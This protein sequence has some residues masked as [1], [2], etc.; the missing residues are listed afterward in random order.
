MDAETKQRFD[1]LFRRPLRDDQLDLVAF[2]VLETVIEKRGVKG[3]AA[4]VEQFHGVL[5]KRKS[6]SMSPIQ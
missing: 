4:L 3:F 6:L 5:K 2:G 1:N